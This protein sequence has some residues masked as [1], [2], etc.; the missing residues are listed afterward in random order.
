MTTH[1]GSQ[2]TKPR[3]ANTR[4]GLVQ[5]GLIRDNVFFFMSLRIQENRL[6]SLH[7]FHMDN[8]ESIY[9]GSIAGC[10]ESN[11]GLIWIWYLPDVFQS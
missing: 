8:E 5:Q 2:H 7:H 4:L 11:S 3:C 9:V 10:G 6:A 1:H